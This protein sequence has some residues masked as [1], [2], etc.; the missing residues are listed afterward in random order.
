M[1][2]ILLASTLVAAVLLLVVMVPGGQLETRSFAHLP[3]SVFWGFNVFLISLG[4]ASF[5]VAGGAIVGATWA[6][7]AALVLG[8]AYVLVFA[9]DL[10]KIFPA[11]PDEMGTPL[12]LLEV[13]DLVV[14]GIIVVVAVGGMIR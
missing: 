11:T 6:P 12:L 1:Y 4:L 10:A 3:T 8:V 14:G 5:V 9:L 2:D 13:A 7:I